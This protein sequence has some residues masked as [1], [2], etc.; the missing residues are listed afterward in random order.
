MGGDVMETSILL[1]DPHDLFREGLRLILEE[2]PD[3]RVV[4]DACDGPTALDLA[5]RLRPDI[6]VSEVALPRLSGL[7]A[8]RRM[9]EDGRGPKLIFLSMHESRPYVEEALRV[10][11]SAYLVKSGGSSE[12]LQAIDAVRRG[13][14]YLSPAVVSHVLGGVTRGAGQ[15]GSSLSALSNRERE[16]LQL[17]AEGLSSKEIAGSLGVAVKTVDSHRARL[18]DKVGIHKL[19]GLVRFAIREGLVAP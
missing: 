5:R 1:V 11:A 9:V 8:G 10:G 18:M 13:K 19:S 7:E 3:L 2:R 15:V 12:L 14:I 16:V 6:V 4:G 17:I